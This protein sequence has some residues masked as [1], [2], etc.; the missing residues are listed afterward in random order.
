[1]SAN[2]FIKS[3][4]PAL[5]KYIS[6]VFFVPGNEQACKSTDVYKTKSLLT[7]SLYAN[8]GRDKINKYMYNVSDGNGAIKILS[9]AGG[10]ECWDM[11]PRC[12]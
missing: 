9:Q 10:R 6:S 8:E 4:F 5:S 12:F 11:V 2:L 3:F 7:W 1:M